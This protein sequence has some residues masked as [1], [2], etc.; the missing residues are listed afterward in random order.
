MCGIAGTAGFSN[1]SLITDML[2]IMKHRGPDETGSFSTTHFSIAQARLSIIDLSTGTQP[3]YDERKKIIAVCNGEIY[4]YIALRESLIKQ[5]HVF[6]TNSDCEVIPHLYEQYGIDFIHMLDGMFS[7]ALLDLYSNK[8]FLIR[9]MFGIKPLYYYFSHGK[10]TFASE[11]KAVLLDSRYRKGINNR[12]LQCFLNFRFVLGEDTLFK[13]IKK[14]LPGHYL[15]YTKNDIVTVPYYTPALKKEKRK[16][17]EEYIEELHELLKDAVSK[18]MM[19]DVPFGLFL[20]G[21][22]DSSALLAYVTKVLGKSIDSFTLGFN[23]PGRDEITDAKIIAQYCNSRHFYVNQNVDIAKN[24]PKTIWHADTPKVNIIQNYLVSK[25]A[26]RN[27]KMALSGMGGDELFGGYNNYKYASKIQ[28]FHAVIPQW[29]QTIAGEIPR[30]LIF[31]IENAIGNLKYDFPRRAL[32]LLLS[33]GNSE[34]F[35]CILRN[36]WDH[37]SGMYR[38]IY[39]DAYAQQQKQYSAHTYIKD[40]F[41]THAS[42]LNQ[43]MLCEIK[44]KMVNDQLLVEDKMS[45]A[46]SL[47]SRVPL[48]DKK[49]VEF[50]LRLPADLKIKNN[51]TK[52]LFKKLLQRVLPEKILMKKKQGFGFDAKLQFEKDIRAIAVQIL[53]EEKIKKQGIFN[54]QYLH[55]IINTPPSKNLE[56]HYY[57]LWNI[58]GFQIW[59]KQFFIDDPRTPELDIQGYY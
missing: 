41:S 14:I 9:D 20:S 45:M 10:L 2:K 28:P 53:T 8:L 50:S 42:Y 40:C 31:I 19:S 46:N 43:V 25:F 33:I 13:G 52:Y 22:V 57:Y 6:T 37:D 17:E 15:V 32:Q 55:A 36:V 23:E 48:L 59:Y 56:W 38:M 5:G 47:E 3:M 11:T 27:I 18:R 39:S 30:R 24:L 58:I 49:I 29:A 44:N 16:R 4:N 34:L 51:T 26:R 21:G 35:Y 7:I 54:Y 12:A 1:T